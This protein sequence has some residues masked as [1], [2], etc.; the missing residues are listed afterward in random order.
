MT[1]KE[2][3]G[4]R[5]EFGPLSPSITEHDLLLLNHRQW[6]HAVHGIEVQDHRQAKMGVTLHLLPGNPFHH[7]IQ[8]LIFLEFNV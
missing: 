3:K 7:L 5:Q 1:N 4:G 6:E 8:N 2:G